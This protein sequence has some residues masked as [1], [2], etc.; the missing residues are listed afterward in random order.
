MALSSTGSSGSVAPPSSSVSMAT[1]LPSQMMRAVPAPVT[2]N[3]PPWQCSMGLPASRQMVHISP[4]TYLWAAPPVSQAAPMQAASPSCCWTQAPPSLC[5]TQSVAQTTPSLCQAQ[6]VAPV[7]QAVVVGPGANMAAGQTQVSACTSSPEVNLTAGSG[8][9]VARVNSEVMSLS[10]AASPVAGSVHVGGRNLAGSVSVAAPSGSGS[11]AQTRTR[12]DQGTAVG[13]QPTTVSRVQSARSSIRI[14][15]VRQRWSGSMDSEEVPTTPTKK[16]CG[17]VQ[18]RSSPAQ[19]SS[20]VQ[21]SGWQH[22]G[23]PS[24][25]PAQYLFSAEKSSAPATGSASPTLNSLSEAP[26]PFSSTPNEV[27]AQGAVRSGATPHFATSAVQGATHF[28]RLQGPMTPARSAFYSA[29]P[30]GLGS[31]GGM[32]CF[33]SGGTPVLPFLASPGAFPLC[34][35]APHIVTPAPAPP[36]LPFGSMTPV[37]RQGNSSQGMTPGPNSAGGREDP[38]NMPECRD[39]R[40]GDYTSACMAEWR[41]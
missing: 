25:Q 29:A 7:A 14:T 39:V 41:H 16:R 19:P 20:P 4:G 38:A 27:S 26:H 3:P 5:Q 23:T 31:S 34:R 8:C 15:P 1:V 10:A 6:L 40:E 2:V 35:P 13:Q 21:S 36:P 32:Q 12:Q 24:P 18:D 17:S 11:G 9:R 22:V 28:V 30:S 37:H 33:S